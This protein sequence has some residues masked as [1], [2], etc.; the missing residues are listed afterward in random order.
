M[1]DQRTAVAAVDLVHDEDTGQ[2][3]RLGAIH[4]AVGAEFDA[5]VRIDHDRASFDRGQRGQRG[6]A[7]VG[8]ARGVDQIDMAVTAVDRCNHRVERLLAFL[9]HRVEIGNRCTALDGAGSTDHAS[10][11]QQ[12]LEQRGLAR[13]GMTDERDISDAFGGVGHDR[14]LP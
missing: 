5:V 8:G 6:T 14:S 3:A 10:C 12:G 2:A 1:F 9:F 4:Q 13:G 7:E 11:V